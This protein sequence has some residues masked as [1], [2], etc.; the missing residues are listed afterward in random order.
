VLPDIRCPT[1]MVFVDRVR[2]EWDRVGI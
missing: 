2:M 1:A